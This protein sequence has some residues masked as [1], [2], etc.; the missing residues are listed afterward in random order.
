M[1]DAAV[2]NAREMGVSENVT[3]PMT[4]NLRAFIRMTG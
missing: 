4:G 3:I 1:V 2:A